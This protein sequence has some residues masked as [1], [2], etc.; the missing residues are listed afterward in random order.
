[1]SVAEYSD[2]LEQYNYDKNIHNLLLIK[3]RRLIILLKDILNYNIELYRRLLRNPKQEIELIKDAIINVVRYSHIPDNLKNLLDVNHFF[4]VGFVGCGKLIAISDLRAAVHLNKMV[5][6]DGIVTHMGPIDVLPLRTVPTVDES[7][8]FKF[9]Q[10][11]DKTEIDYGEE[12]VFKSKQFITVQDISN[13]FGVRTRQIQ[14]RCYDFTDACKIGD[15]I[16]IIGVYEIYSTY[17]Q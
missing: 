9:Y 17:V 2:F 5:F 4:T 14:V 7:K 8:Y 13:S 15:K 16:R 6:I 10:Y 12:C 3:E 11:H 1:M